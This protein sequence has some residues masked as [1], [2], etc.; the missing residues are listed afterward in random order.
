MD[1]IERYKDYPEGSMG[2]K[3]YDR[4]D[5]LM[6]IFLEKYY[7]EVDLSRWSRWIK[8]YVEP[9]FDES[10]HEEMARN[11]GYVS[12]SAHDFKA[13]NKIYDELKENHDMDEGLKK[14]VAFMGGGGFFDIYKISLSEWL[15]V[16]NW[17]HPDPSSDDKRKPLSEILK[18]PY[19]LNY[20]KDSL[21]QI[22]FWNR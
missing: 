7:S 11:F 21:T 16:A 1:N 9:S 22:P 8:Q 10:R 2:K 20:I 12:V 3:I 15:S 14:F 4:H 6:E 13:Q 18:I 17:T 19:G 5:M